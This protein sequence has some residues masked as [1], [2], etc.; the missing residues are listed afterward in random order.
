MVKKQDLFNARLYSLRNSNRFKVH[1]PPI[2]I[3]SQKKKYK[4]PADD[5]RAALKIFQFICFE[6]NGWYL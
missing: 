2:N 1:L 5:R 6:M 4:R 3:V